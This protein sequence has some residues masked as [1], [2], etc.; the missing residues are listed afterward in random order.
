MALPDKQAARTSGLKNWSVWTLH[1][2]KLKLEKK[3]QKT[4]FSLML[5]L[6]M[7]VLKNDKTV[8]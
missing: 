1:T 8:K 3:M 7:H 4:N 6:N 2:E 5:A